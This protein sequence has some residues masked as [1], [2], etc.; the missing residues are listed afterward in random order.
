MTI[1]QVVTDN[2]RIDTDVSADIAVGAAFAIDQF[3]LT[4]AAGATGSITGATLQTVDY[5]G[6]GAVVTV[7]ACLARRLQRRRPP[8]F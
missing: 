3:T 6:N 8:S 1:A 2:P 4:S 7:V 5:G